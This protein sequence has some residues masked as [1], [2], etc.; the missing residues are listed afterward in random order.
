MTF[1]LN[2][3]NGLYAGWGLCAPRG[4]RGFPVYRPEHWAFADT[5]F[6]MGTT[7]SRRSR[8]RLRGRRPR[9]CRSRRPPERV[10]ERR[11]SGLADPRARPVS[12]K[13]EPLN[14]PLD[15][16]SCQ[17]TTP[18]S[19]GDPDWRCERCAVNQVK[20]GAGM[21]VNF[22]AVEVRCSMPAVANG[23]RSSAARSLVE[24]VTQNVLTRYLKR[25]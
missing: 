1:G 23:S 19:W 12:L 7:R 13:E 4:V 15:D 16:R 24:R 9:L 10:D 22:G 21:I 25:R 18:S 17:T 5:G 2:A 8:L 11:A 3:T 20:R 14:V 6:V